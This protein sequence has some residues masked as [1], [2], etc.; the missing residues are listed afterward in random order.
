MT[1]PRDKEFAS[2]I[3]SR[4]RLGR[5]R[6]PPRISTSALSPDFRRVLIDKKQTAR[7]LNLSVRTVDHRIR[8]GELPSVK[9]GDR[10]LISLA[11]L[12][13]IAEGR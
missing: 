7:L 8:S 6:K 12:F 13:A 9:I 5:P 10:R 1:S 11:A 2:G 3:E 4:A